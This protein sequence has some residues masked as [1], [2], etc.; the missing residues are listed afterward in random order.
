M[1]TKAQRNFEIWNLFMTRGWTQPRIAL[2]YK[3]SQ[4]RV[5]QIIREEEDNGAMNKALGMLKK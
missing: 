5:S 2:H 1:K 4:G 3:L